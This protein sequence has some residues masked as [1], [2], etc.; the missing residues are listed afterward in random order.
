MKARFLGHDVNQYAMLTEPGDMAIGAANYHHNLMVRCPIC[1]RLHVVDITTG[2]KP[3]G[4]PGRWTFDEAT[5][6]LSASF[7]CNQGSLTEY[8]HWSLA[9]GEFTIHPD[10]TRKPDP[11]DGD[12]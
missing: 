3:S 2:T 12:W 1:H 5:L 7:A 8:C 10:S 11:N 9:N 6:T 4:G